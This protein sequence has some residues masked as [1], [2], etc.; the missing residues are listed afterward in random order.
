MK[1]L[2]V[3]HGEAA[4]DPYPEL[5]RPL[6][7]N[8]RRSI[9][10][11]AKEIQSLDLKI[12]HIV[13]SPLTRAIQTAEIL[14]CCFRKNHPVRHVDCQIELASEFL[15]D[16]FGRES[17]FSFLGALYP[18]TL[19]LVGHEPGLLTLAHWLDPLEFQKNIPS[20]LKKG[21]AF[22]FEWNPESEGHFH[23]RISYSKR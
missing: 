15:P 1:I 7:S 21:S 10:G 3:R 5:L 11:L 23:G 16:S 19:L 22:F 2:L 8:G 9:R 6:T 12:D 14:L 13:S 20:G 17:F 18:D 4:N